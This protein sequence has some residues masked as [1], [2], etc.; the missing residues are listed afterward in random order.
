MSKHEAFIRVTGLTDREIQHYLYE[1]CNLD[2]MYIDWLGSDML[3]VRNADNEWFSC[4]WRSHTYNVTW[5]GMQTENLC[6]E[7]CGGNPLAF[8]FDCHE[9]MYLDEV[10]F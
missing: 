4:N 5:Y 9:F 10:S 8:C 7:S 6:C 2:G 3:N 1:S